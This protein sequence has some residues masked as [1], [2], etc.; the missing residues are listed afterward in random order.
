[1]KIIKKGHDENRMQVV[2]KNC[3]AVLEITSADVI[4]EPTPDS[5]FGRHFYK[6][7]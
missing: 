4:H 5:A 2:C 1:M 3:E 6:C 7:P